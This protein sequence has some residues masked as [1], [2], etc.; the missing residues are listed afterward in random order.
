MVHPVAVGSRQT[1]VTFA[2]L[3]AWLS[4]EPRL[5]VLSLAAAWALTAEPIVIWSRFWWSLP[6]V[7][8]MLT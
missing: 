1:P 4:E 5:P 8:G 7:D 3:E 2:T 6:P